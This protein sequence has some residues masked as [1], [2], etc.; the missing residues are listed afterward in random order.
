MSH[1]SLIQL[2]KTIIQ[3]HITT[4]QA[5][6]IAVSGGPDS[7]VALHILQLFWIE[8]NW[9]ISLIHILTC[10]HNT[11]EN[12]QKEIDLVASVCHGS[13]M[14]VFSYGWSDYSEQSL[15]QRRH[16]QFISYCKNNTIH[17]IITWH[18]LDDRIETTLL[19][20]KRGSN[21]TGIIS[22]S[23]SDF[24]FLDH[25]ISIL[26]PLINS[27]KSD[28]LNYCKEQQIPYAI[29]PTNTDIN[30]SER[31][32]IRQFIHD[33]LNTNNFYKSWHT[34]YQILQ[35]HNNSRSSLSIHQISNSLNHDLITIT[36]WERTPD[37]LYELYTH[38]H[39]SLNP[40]SNT[41]DNLCIQLNQ[42]SGNKISYQWLTIT[43]Y[44]YASTIKKIIE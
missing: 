30:Y 44:S 15:R 43:A 7:M 2:A 6:A 17:H 34:L 13:S 35:E 18:H 25:T 26:R 40:R 24:H 1:W 12:I 27:C 19:N 41:L 8:Q 38:Y 37:K 33:H 4:P 10:D 42:R 31:N 22:I 36:S 16:E 39:L 14:K 28:I 5:I 29:D 21:I 9:D 20:M 23:E 32:L 11:R 3:Q